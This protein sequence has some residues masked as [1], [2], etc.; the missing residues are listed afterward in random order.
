MQSDLDKLIDE[1]RKL[2]KEASRDW[3][4]RHFGI[5][6]KGRTGVCDINPNSPEARLMVK[7]RNALPAIIAH[8]EELRRLKAEREGEAT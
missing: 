1:L 4:A 2:D 8:L 5:S 6:A 3:Y 7:A